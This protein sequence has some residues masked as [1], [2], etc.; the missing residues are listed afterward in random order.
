MVR[1][2]KRDEMH[3]MN[4]TNPNTGLRRTWTSPDPNGQVPTPTSSSH[5][6]P[7]L[8]GR[9]LEN[10]YTL[11]KQRNNVQ[12][13]ERYHT[14]R[15]IYVLRTPRVN[16]KRPASIIYLL[17]GLL[18][19]ALRRRRRPIRRSSTP[20]LLHLILLLHLVDTAFL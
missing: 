5:A 20:R 11:Q 16:K 9:E 13:R 10:R 18:L 1:D 15:T 17:G 19:L 7:R 12:S 8:E 3:R 4:E 2:W 14:V 6:T